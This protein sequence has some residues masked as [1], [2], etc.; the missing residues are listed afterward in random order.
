M[1][2]PTDIGPIHFVGIGGIG[3]S[4]I[5]EVLLN[6]GYTVQGSDTADRAN[7]KRLRARARRSRSATRRRISARREVVVVSSA[8]KRDNPELAAARAQAPAGGAA[9][10]DARR[11]DAPEALRRDRRH[12]RQDHDDHDG[13][14]PARCRRPRSDRGQRRH[15]QRLRHQRAARRG[16]LDGGRGRRVRRHVPEA[17]GRRRGRHQHRSRALDHFETSRRSRPRST[18]SSRTC[19]STASP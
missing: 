1:K 9:R 16:R 4:G 12:A 18:T 17:A 6:L 19:R 13:R 10:R 11:A 15:H 3:M 7:V 2:M 5:A 8:I 14:G